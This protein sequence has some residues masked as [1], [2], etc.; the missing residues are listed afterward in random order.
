[1]LPASYLEAQ[2]RQTV[3]SGHAAGGDQVGMEFG[4]F[5]IRS[6]GRASVYYRS[7]G[8]LVQCR[9]QEGASVY[10]RSWGTL[11]QCRTQERTLV[12][13]RT[14]GRASVYYNSWGTLV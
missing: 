8:T 5:V 4:M 3:C 11:V 6:Q 2:R 10:Y 1:M 13:C 7:W 9:T 12:Q 14:Q